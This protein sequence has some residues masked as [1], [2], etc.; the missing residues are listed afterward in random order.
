MKQ[1]QQ[2]T[3]LLLQSKPYLTLGEGTIMLMIV[4]RGINLNIMMVV[5]F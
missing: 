3:Q 2:L 4:D 5:S 1:Q